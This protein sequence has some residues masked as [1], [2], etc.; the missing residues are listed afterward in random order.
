VVRASKD[1]CEAIQRLLARLARVTGTARNV[2]IAQLLALAGLRRLHPLVLE[3]TRYIPIIINICENPFFR[4]VFEEGKQE[5]RQES[6]RE[7]AVALLCRQLE[8]RFGTLTAATRQ[9]I[10]TADTST[11][12]TWS[13]RVLE[14]TSLDEVLRTP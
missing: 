10:E 12:E 8:H 13:L 2:A 5:G 4:E 11:L 9:Q 14:A 1:Y 3:E 7:E 6:R